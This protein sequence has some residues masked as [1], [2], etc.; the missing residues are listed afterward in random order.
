[1][2]QIHQP[3]IPPDSAEL[4][5]SLRALMQQL[6][7]AARPPGQPQ[8]ARFFDALRAICLTVEPG[9]LG[10]GG[11][12]DLAGFLAALSS[13]EDRVCG[14]SLDDESSLDALMAVLAVHGYLSNAA[15]PVLMDRLSR[16]L[17]SYR[18]EFWQQDTLDLDADRPVPMNEPVID[19]N[20]LGVRLMRPV[21][22][23]PGQVVDA[24][25]TG[26]EAFPAVQRQGPTL[27]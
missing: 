14:G 20:T 26:W 16:T 24:E 25:E 23:R 8:S 11:R 2:T 18:S 27:H 17:A 13:I 9:L 10:P 5:V 19:W 12:S 7:Q 4:P 15:R 21:S 6:G 22:D 1:M 3:P